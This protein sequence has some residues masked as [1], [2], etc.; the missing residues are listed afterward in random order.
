MKNKNYNDLKKN[1]SKE[2]AYFARK[3]KE[4]MEE[5]KK[6]KE[7]DEKKK[8]IEARK[9]LHFMKCPKCGA[10]LEEIEFKDINIDLCTEC[11]GL[12]LDQGELRSIL[13]K[14]SRLVKSLLKGFFRDS[15]F[16]K[17]N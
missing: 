3:D 15:D 8:A 13:A 10:D 9:K 6:K 12:W 14:E 5:V 4:L 2:D 17:I 16:D 1:V 7:S 11:K